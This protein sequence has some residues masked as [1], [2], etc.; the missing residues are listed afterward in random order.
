[1]TDEATK[2]LP[3]TDPHRVPSVFVNELAGSGSLNG[4]VNLTFATAMFTPMSD[5][6]VDPDLV[7]T[8]RLRMDLYCAQQLLVTL[9]QI[10]EQNTKMPEG[11]KAN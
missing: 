5:G 7:I 4:V 9:T 6:T 3:V 2:A 8:S 11:T 1:M 10:V